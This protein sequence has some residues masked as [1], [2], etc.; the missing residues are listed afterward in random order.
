MC[1]SHTVEITKNLSHTFFS[2]I[3]V[4]SQALNDWWGSRGTVW[5]FKNFSITQILREINFGEFKSAKSAVFAILEALNFC[6]YYFLR[7]LNDKIT[8]FK[9]PKMSKTA[10]L[11]FWFHVKSTW[12][13]NPEIFA[14]GYFFL[15]QFLLHIWKSISSLNDYV[16]SKDT[17]E[18]SAI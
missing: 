8:K 2:K 14:M 11:E 1:S 16:P 6:F 13:K 15:G 5:K 18:N 10:I 4:A 12:H 17:I 7:F 9:A 3:S